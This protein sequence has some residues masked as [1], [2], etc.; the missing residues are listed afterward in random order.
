[1]FVKLYYCNCRDDREARAARRPYSGQ[2]CCRYKKNFSWGVIFPHS[3]YE[4]VSKL[5]REIW[6]LRSTLQI[7][8]FHLMGE[9]WERSGGLGCYT[10]FG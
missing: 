7:L 2:P 9:V 1:M 5:L 4:D 10:Q 3:N 8:V 6:P